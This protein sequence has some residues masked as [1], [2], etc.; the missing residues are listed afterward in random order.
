MMKRKEHIQEVLRARNQSTW[1]ELDEEIKGWGTTRLT[2]GQ[3]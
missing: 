1:E 2:H 3:A